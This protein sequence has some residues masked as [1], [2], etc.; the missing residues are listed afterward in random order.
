VALQALLPGTTRLRVFVLDIETGV[1]VPVDLR[2]GGPRWMTWSGPY[3][4]YVYDVGAEGDSVLMSWDSRT[5]RR[6]VVERTG[7]EQFIDG[8]FSA[9][10]C[11]SSSG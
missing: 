9:P 6:A 1:T 4:L 3:L 7:I 5:Q 11:E 10:R 2:R 8:P